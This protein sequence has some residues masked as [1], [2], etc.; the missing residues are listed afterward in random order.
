MEVIESFTNGPYHVSLG[1]VNEC[2]FVTVTTMD[3]K[4]EYT[5]NSPE[6]AKFLYQEL[7]KEHSRD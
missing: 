3:L 7:V 2:Y 6:T 4:S 1:R 5:S